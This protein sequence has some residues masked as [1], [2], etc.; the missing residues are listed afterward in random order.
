MTQRKLFCNG[1]SFR[2]APLGTAYGDIMR[3]GGFSPVEVPHDWMI[4]DTHALYRTGE[5]W[6]RRSFDYT[7]VPK[8]RTYLRFEGVYMDA[9]VFVNGDVACEWKYGYTTFEADL[10]DLLTPEKNDIVVR[11]VYRDPNTRWYSGA[12]IYRRVWLVNAPETR[13]VS[14][15]VYISA[16]KKTAAEWRLRVR[17][18]TTAASGTLTHTLTDADGAVVATFT[19]EVKDGRGE[20]EA[21][22]SS[23]RVWD[24]DDTYMYT[25]KTELAVGGE[26]V[27]A[28]SDRFGFREIYFDAERGF[29]I[30]G[31]HLKLHG[32]CEHHDLGALGAA[33]SVPA[34]R[35]KLVMLRS[36]GVNS[37]RTS[38]NPPAVELLELCDEMG[39][40]VIDESF[41]M[42]EH[43]KTSND[44]ASFF[45][46]WHE[47]D[48][49]SWVTRDRN[50]PCVI[51]WSIGNEI[52]DTTSLRGIEMTAR[53]VRL[54]RIWDPY[55]N[56]FTTSGSNHMRSENAQKCGAIL[57]VVGYNYAE[58]LYDEHHKKY[59]TYR[60]YGSETASTVQSRGIY[61]FPFT[62]KFL[63]H[64]DHQCSS[65]FNCTTSWGSKST[66]YNITEDRRAEFCAGQ[67]IWTGFDYIGEPTPYDTKNS[68]FGQ[69]DTAG[70]PKDSFYAYRAEWT[71]GKKA[72]FVHITPSYWDFNPGEPVDVTVHTNAAK[73]ELY[74]DGVLVSSFDHDHER[75]MKMSSFWQVPYRPG[76]L[77]AIAY[78]ENGAV[79]ARDEV[80]SSGDPARIVLTADKS[81]F[82]GNGRDMCFVSISAEDSDG[83]FVGNARNRMN[84]TVTGSGRLVGL[85]NGDSTDYEQYKCSSRR[86]FSGRLLAIVA[87]DGTAGSV[88]VTVTS[89][90]L[91]AASL[92]LTASP[93][94]IPEGIEIIDKCISSPLVEEVPLRKLELSASARTLD[95]EHPS[96]VVT[97]RL[98]PE[99]TTYR[100]VLWSALSRGMPAGFV[101]IEPR[102]DGASALVTALSDGDFI[103][104][105]H[106]NVGTPYPAVISELSFAAAG[107][108]ETRL[109]PYDDIPGALATEADGALPER[110]GGIRFTGPGSRV[111][112]R[113]VDFGALGSDELAVKL[114]RYHIPDLPFRV[115]DVTDGGSTSLGEF[116]FLADQ[117]WNT[118]AT[119]IYKLSGVLRGVRDIMFV[120]V[121]PL[122]FGGFRASAIER[123]FSR[124]DAS[125][126]DVLYGDA[127]TRE[128][129]A[130]S[131]IGNNVTVGFTSLDFGGGAS[132][133]TVRG[134]TRRERDAVELRVGD[135]VISVEFVRSES[136]YEVTVPVTG[137]SG[138]RDVNA[139]FLP[140]SDFDLYWIKFE[141]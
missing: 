10:T 47:R 96:A 104:R 42:W 39:F 17:T 29:F 34:L 68:Y 83:V 111:V 130:V 108:G 78:D 41:D 73:S 80:R 62:S 126:C 105:A 109:N 102:D 119:G 24:P 8:E 3:D 21:V 70:F 124:L 61:H 136:P 30:N 55:K 140:G 36:M 38:H 6:Y 63:T 113:G 28:S 129:D 79:V 91:P 103:L 54:V 92:T 112:F 139:V 66:E 82:I 87:S 94:A 7:P 134:M 117:P 71:D 40:L 67:Y 99:N 127:F 9:T 97:A 100:E 75:G 57:D 93:A 35:R 116:F 90:G 31:R 48:V 59:P 114:M 12:G 11:C 74:F 120:F 115:Y 77:T 4:Y 46:E 18:D 43:H 52:G 118:Y 101:R 121:Q 27:D 86:L 15:G 89:P 72:P 44:Y 16:S 53:L 23:P 2:E 138:V 137:V 5:G 45:P 60:I 14:D 106:S 76:A 88:T 37:I 58:A 49:R 1:W 32:V 51:M 132:S 50:H 33:V 65:L 131:H 26:T 95:S 110:D 56:A 123:A 122:I 133:V 64:D 135:E 69:I 19:A 22:V 98:L 141:K 84:V 81:T 125:D 13:I 107:I 128:K 20:G 25:L 85:D